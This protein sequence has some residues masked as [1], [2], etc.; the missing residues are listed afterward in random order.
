MDGLH[1]SIN[2]QAHTQLAHVLAVDLLD[3]PCTVHCIQVVTLEHHDHVALTVHQIQVLGVVL[4]LKRVATHIG[5]SMH[6]GLLV[7]DVVAGLLG[8]N[9]IGELQV[10][11]TQL[12]NAVNGV[13]AVAAI[14]LVTAVKVQI[15]ISALLG[16]DLLLVAQHH[17]VP[18]AVQLL[19]GIG[20]SDFTHRLLHIGHD[21]FHLNATFLEFLVFLLA[22]IHCCRSQQHRQ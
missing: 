6:D 12:E 22:G 3:E 11:A 15:Q 2:D 14:H 20:D 21:V 7:S 1:H 10:I 17:D 5:Q 16:V 18:L 4:C 19:G 13:A 8:G 9:E